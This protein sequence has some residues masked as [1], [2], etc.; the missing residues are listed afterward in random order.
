MD[1]QPAN[2]ANNVRAS[3]RKLLGEAHAA[4]MAN[5]YTVAK[6][7]YTKAIGFLEKHVGR[8]HWQTADLLHDVSVVHRLKDEWPEAIATIKKA[9]KIHER[10]LGRKSAPYCKDLVPWADC[11]RT[12]SYEGADD[13]LALY[14]KA[15]RQ[16]NRLEESATTVRAL[17]GAGRCWLGRHRNVK[18]VISFRRWHEMAIRVHGPDH[19][20][21]IEL[22]ELRDL[23][24][25]IAF[26]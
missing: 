14:N 19:P 26:F 6:A 4:V 21:T 2:L 12:S 24:N 25:V 20:A 7:R 16:L 8:D 9:A 10:S 3:M 15:L 1:A 23:A 18:A 22:K 11:I 13:A 17:A 5:K